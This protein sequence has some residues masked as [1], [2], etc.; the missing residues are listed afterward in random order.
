MPKVSGSKRSP[1]SAGEA[2]VDRQERD[3]RDERRAVAGGKAVAAPDRWLSEQ[4]RRNERRGAEPLLPEQQHGRD[5]AERKEAERHRQ[6]SRIHLLDL[7]QGENDRAHEHRE[8]QEP[9]GIEPGAP[10]VGLDGLETQ[11]QQCGGDPER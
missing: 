7:L 5:R 9:R 11:H 2:Q 8:Q 4:A 6:R 3:Q 10:A 1:V